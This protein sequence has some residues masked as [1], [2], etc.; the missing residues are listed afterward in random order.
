MRLQSL[1]AAYLRTPGRKESLLAVLITRCTAPGKVAAEIGKENPWKQVWELAL[2]LTAAASELLQH[3]WSEISR[4]ISM[5][6]YVH[7]PKF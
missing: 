7:I 4:R 6:I 2:I 5:R 1:S 3:G